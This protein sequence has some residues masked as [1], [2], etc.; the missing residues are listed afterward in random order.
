MIQKLLQK[1]LGVSRHDH[2]FGAEYEWDRIEFYLE[3]KPQ[4]LICPRCRTSRGVIRKGSRCRYLQSVPIGF[5]AVYRVTE[6]AR[7]QCRRCE[8]MFEVHP[9]LPGRRCALRA[10]W[11]G[12]WTD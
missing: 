3:I 8:G 5:Q 10:S 9:P 1:V 6:V 7:G 12:W 2:C 4:G 11:R